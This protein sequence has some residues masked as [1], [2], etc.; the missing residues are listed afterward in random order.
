M[1]VP[2]HPSSND[3]N[4]STDAF[5]RSLIDEPEYTV[6]LDELLEGLETEDTTAYDRTARRYPR[7]AAPLLEAALIALPAERRVREAAAAYADAPA[8]V[9]AA[10]EAGIG[11]ARRELG[12]ATGTAL[13]IADARKERG[14]TVGELA[15]RLHLS[16]LLATKIDRGQMTTWSERLTRAVAEA[17]ET[18]R[19]AAGAMLTATAGNFRA[20]AA[21][22][23]SAE[24]APD[25]ALVA[26]RRREGLDFETELTKDRLT[27]EQA[28][29]W[30]Q[31]S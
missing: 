18:T 12:L 31:E 3:S 15:R 14:W 1:N 7:Y 10:V 28:A 16:S 29:Y 27:P 26:Q 13:T 23:Y 19:D 6:A 25:A 30:R 9:T 17:F 8:E 20:P 5:D 11:A 2:N 4:T 24:G 22:A 21:S